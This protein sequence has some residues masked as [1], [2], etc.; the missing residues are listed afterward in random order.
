MKTTWE[1]QRSC[2]KTAWK[3]Y[4]YRTN[5]PRKKHED[6]SSKS[7]R[8]VQIPLQFS[9]REKLQDTLYCVT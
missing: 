9:W 1:L 7:F 5:S 8:A 6:S 3:L 2:V 4:E